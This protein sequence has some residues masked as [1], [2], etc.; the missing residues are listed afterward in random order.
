MIKQIQEETT[1]LGYRVSLYS[2]GSQ[3]VVTLPSAGRG[4][5]YNQRQYPRYRQS[6]L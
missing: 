4:I 1:N 3:F 6:L 5:N 2:L